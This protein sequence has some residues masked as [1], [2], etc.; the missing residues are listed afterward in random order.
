[1]QDMIK[2]MTRS[3]VERK[4]QKDRKKKGTADLT[5]SYLWE[6]CAGNTLRFLFFQPHILHSRHG[7]TSKKKKKGKPLCKVLFKRLRLWQ[8]HQ[9]QSGKMKY[10]YGKSFPVT[11]QKAE[12]YFLNS[13]LHLLF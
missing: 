4:R 8:Q 10:S 11:L 13:P 9:V 5:S 1:M 2:N 3:P 7:I 6:N 12:Y